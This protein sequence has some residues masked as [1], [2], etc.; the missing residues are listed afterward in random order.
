MRR[1]LLLLP[2]L[3]ASCGPAISQREV[4]GRAKAEVAL[5]E[6]WADSALVVVKKKPAF[7]WSLWKIQ[8]G[9]LDDSSFPIYEGLDMLP[10]TERQLLFARN[11]CLVRYEERTSGCADR[12]RMAPARKTSDK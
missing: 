4:L 8:A 11:G 10:G 3:L 1:L 5:R 12:Y 6:P 2:V 9:Q 7:A